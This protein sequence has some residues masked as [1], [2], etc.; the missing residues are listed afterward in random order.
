MRFGAWIST[1]GALG[2]AQWNSEK[3]HVT[4]YRGPVPLDDDEYVK[5]WDSTRRV[6]KLV[7]LQH[8]KNLLGFRIYRVSEL[9]RAHGKSLNTVTGWRLL[10]MAHEE[11]KRL[12]KDR[13]ISHIT[14]MEQDR[15]LKDIRKDMVGF[16]LE[17]TN[18]R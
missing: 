13:T 9:L 17:L 15:F 2:C 6:S 12:Y 7:G 18:I 8:D 16:K 14:C 3:D 11:A 5:I 1:K 10:D 4:F